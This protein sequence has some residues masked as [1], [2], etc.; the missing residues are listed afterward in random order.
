MR[1]RMCYGTI[2][3]TCD[4]I[5]GLSIGQDVLFENLAGQAVGGIVLFVDTTVVIVPITTN[6]DLASC[7]LTSRSVCFDFLDKPA[8]NFHI[9]DRKHFWY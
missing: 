2:S 6:V 9:F 3:F 7:L 4:D 1:P 8:R 5:S